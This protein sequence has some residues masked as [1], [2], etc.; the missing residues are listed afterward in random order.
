MSL[1]E[2]LT[3]FLK[4][5]EPLLSAVRANPNLSLESI[6]SDPNLKEARDKLVARL[7][8]ESTI[9]QLLQASAQLRKQHK[10]LLATP[11]RTPE[12]LRKLGVL[13]DA[14]LVLSAEALSSAATPWSMFVYTMRQL[15]PWVQR[16]VDVGLLIVAVI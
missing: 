8:Q 13:A 3:D 16:A 12:D 15:L 4:Q 11:N 5:A 10:D 1:Q 2:I 14:A 9:E 7:T 6:W